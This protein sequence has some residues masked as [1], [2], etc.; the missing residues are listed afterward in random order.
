MTKTLAK[1]DKEVID[2]LANIEVSQESIVQASSFFEKLCSN[3][4][5]N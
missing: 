1:L 4:T 3:P 2:I 5:S